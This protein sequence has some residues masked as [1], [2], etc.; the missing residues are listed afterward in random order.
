VTSGALICFDDVRAIAPDGHD[1]M[2]DKNDI[3]NGGTNMLWRIAAITPASGT[4]VGKADQVTLR[5]DP[6]DRTP[7]L[8]PC[9]WVTTSEAAAIL[10]VPSVS[11][12]PSGD[13]A[14]SVDQ[15][16]SYQSGNHLVTSTVQLPGS[17]AVDARSELELA[18]AAGNGNATNTSGLP[19]PAYCGL[20]KGARGPDNAALTVLLNGDRI[21][22][23]W[24]APCDVLKQFAEIAIPRIGGGG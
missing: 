19:G 16:C 23:A 8:R 24:G 1:V 14:G 4:P 9:D 12:L 20:P 22:R 10:G 18:I 6:A 13:E 17:F 11:T 2:N 5:L 15:T 21:Y 7:A 3:M